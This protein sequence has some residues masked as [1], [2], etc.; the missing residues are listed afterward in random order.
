MEILYLQPKAQEINNQW[1]G[2]PWHF[3]LMATCMDLPIIRFTGYLNTQYTLYWGSGMNVIE[4]RML[5]TSIERR[6]VKGRVG[7]AVKWFALDAP[8][9]YD[10][11]RTVPLEPE[12]FI[13]IKK[14]VESALVYK[15]SGNDNDLYKRHK[16]H[17]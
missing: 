14:F 4:T 3:A 1:D 15:G 12:D 13:E 9:D 5:A 2:D 11:T 16:W 6:K 17:Q 8:S 10:R 7:T